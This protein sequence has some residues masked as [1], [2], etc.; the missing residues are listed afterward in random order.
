MTHMDMGFCNVAI[1]GDSVLH[2]EAVKV[3]SSAVR[4][5]VCFSNRSVLNSAPD[6]DLV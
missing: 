3:I 1:M 2:F 5:C 6:F 4:L